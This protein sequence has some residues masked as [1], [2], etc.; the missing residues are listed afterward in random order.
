MFL[1]CGVEI[2]AIFLVMVCEC[3]AAAAAG[4][5]VVCLF[6]PWLLQGE[7]RVVV[8]VVVVGGGG[9]FDP[10]PTP[11]RLDSS[12]VFGSRSGEYPFPDLA[13]A[14][15]GFLKDTPAKFLALFGI[16][17]GADLDSDRNEPEVPL[18]SG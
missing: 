11:R 9:G 1:C 10:F 4:Q 18:L 7:N 14:L 17:L 16:L 13:V 3:A 6:P 8:V 2:I 5:L 12:L 15:L